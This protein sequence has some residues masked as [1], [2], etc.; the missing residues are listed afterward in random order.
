[1]TNGEALELFVAALDAAGCQPRA[2]GKGYGFLCPVH[3][4][5]NKPSAHAEEGRVQPIVAMCHGCGASYQEIAEAIGVD[6]VAGTTEYLYRDAGGTIVAIRAR[7]GSG[8]TKRIAWF[9]P[10]GSK[11]KPAD[12]PHVPYLL[13]ELLAAPDDCTVY[14]VEGEK[15][16]HTLVNWGLVA[17]TPGAARDPWPPTWNRWF[18]GHDIVILPDN[19][20]DGREFAARI[21][22]SLDA[23]PSIKVVWLP[24][25]GEGGD[26]TDWSREFGGTPA[27]LRALVE[28][29]PVWDAME[30]GAETIVLG[31][32][33][34]AD[35]FVKWGEGRVL[36]VR[37]ESPNNQP[38]LAY[39]G[40][41]WTP[42][43]PAWAMHRV[44]DFARDM[45]E[46]SARERRSQ[47]AKTMAAAAVRMYDVDPARNVL[48]AARGVPGVTVSAKDLDGDPNLLG[49]ANGVVDLRTGRMVEADHHT[50]ITKATTVAWSPLATAPTWLGFLDRIFA[51]DQPTINYMQRAIG[52]TLTGLQ[53]EQCFFV[54]WG[55]GANG[56]TTFV[57]AIQRVMGDY[58]GQAETR[59]LMTVRDRGIPDDL[60]SLIGRR[61]VAAT[62]TENNRYLDVARLKWLTGGD[63]VTSRPLHGTYVTYEPT[64][65]LWLSTNH[66]PQV[67]GND[68]ALWRRL[69][70]VPFNVV[71]PEAERDHQLYNK[72]LAEAPGILRWAVEG[73]TAWRTQG[74][75]EPASVSGATAE[76]RRDMDTVGRF[77][78]ERCEIDTAAEESVGD[79]Y[80][81]FVRWFQ[82]DYPDR[83][84]PDKPAFGRDLETKG[85]EPIKGAKGVRIRRGL[86]L[87]KAAGAF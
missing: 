18:A 21:A 76:Y 73:C 75:N 6:V 87:V 79:L 78:E 19:D 69:R 13:P 4:D 71:I 84:V 35:R 42:Q 2:E 81:A 14:I 64:Y 40:A 17:S 47:V 60:H 68:A 10:D 58:A 31:H 59:L 52:Y 33:Q 49:V 72:L 38:W 25:V 53:D 26:V 41:R 57:R 43:T 45:A 27:K 5:I 22:G 50:L 65:K 1:M 44:F 3:D 85:Y 34:L 46:R 86:R 24:D 32:A 63:E 70:L 29:E 77:I 36:Y 74:L 16:C 7:R 15:D 56:K 37:E 11:G 80:E 62:E 39:D 61:M 83:R 67:P 82:R 55:G 30:A 51:G 54:L 28:R 23:V 20:D 8:K 48:T 66:R 9:G 12:A